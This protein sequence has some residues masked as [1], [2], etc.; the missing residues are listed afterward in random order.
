MVT[1]NVMTENDIDKPRDLVNRLIHL[2][3]EFEAEWD[4]GEGY[5]CLGCY[6]YHTVFTELAPDCRS[7][8]EKSSPA[9]VKSFCD[10]INAFVSAS[11]DKESAV[12]TC[13]L[14]HASQVGIRKIVNPYLSQA[15]KQELR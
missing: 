13:L 8:L 14:E 1:Q 7:Y 10:L 12:S 11:G 4:E 3:P 9:T 6:G 15:A 2:F 5:G